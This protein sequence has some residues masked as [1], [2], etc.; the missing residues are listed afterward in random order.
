L[1]QQSDINFSIIHSLDG[2]DEVSLTGNFKM[3]SNNKDEILSPKDIGFQNLKSETLKSGGTIQ[4]AVRIF[5]SI[6]EGKGSEEQNNVVMA[7]SAM[8][9]HCI[10]QNENF[11]DSVQ[12]AKN[13]LVSGKAL[14][15]LKKLL[16]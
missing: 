2:Y 8:A 10:S 15:S 14:N 9:I 1:Y 13:S 12:E 11:Q 3:I 5:I 4:E 16:N 7:N 6:L